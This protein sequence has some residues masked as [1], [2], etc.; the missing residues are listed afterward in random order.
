NLPEA[1]GPQL[2]CPT[3]IESA[4]PLAHEIFRTPY[5]VS[6]GDFHVVVLDSSNACDGFR[7]DRGVKRYVTLLEEIAAF[8][9][10]TGSTWLLTHRPPWG[11]QRLDE[12]RLVACGTSREYGCINRTLQS[13]IRGTRRGRLPNGIDLVV[14]GH[15]HRFQAITFAEGGRPPQLTVGNGGVELAISPAVE[16]QGLQVDALKAHVLS[17]GDTVSHAGD[18]V[19]AYGFM[20]VDLAI[21]GGWKGE[22]VNPLEGVTIARCGDSEKHERP[23]CKFGKHVSP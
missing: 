17:T 18:R 11:V 19:P 9:P 3:D 23:I 21:G 13:A 15:M 10:K 20:I 12:K 6:V 8:T 22:L 2:H 16:V 1:G 5:R 4:D 7:N 14:S